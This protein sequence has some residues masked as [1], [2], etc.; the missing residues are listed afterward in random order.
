MNAADALAEA[1]RLIAELLAI[2]DGKFLMF[3][4]LDDERVTVAVARR[5]VA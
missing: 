2:M 1:K 4:L 3:V 5:F